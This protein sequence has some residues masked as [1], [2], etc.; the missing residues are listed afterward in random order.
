MR[1]PALSSYASRQT[2]LYRTH[3]LLQRL[4]PA[5]QKQ[6]KLKA[7]TSHQ[8]VAILFLLIAFP[9]SGFSQDSTAIPLRVETEV[10]WN[11]FVHSGVDNDMTIIRDSTQ[12]TDYAIPIGRFGHGPNLNLIISTDVANH[13][14]AGLSIQYYGTR[15]YYG[16]DGG[17]ISAQ[18]ATEVEYAFSRIAS[19]AVFE[20]TAPFRWQLPISVSVRVLLGASFVELRKDINFAFTPATPMFPLFLPPFALHIIGQYSA[21]NPEIGSHLSLAIGILSNVRLKCTV[22]WVFSPST[23]VQGSFS[24]M[25]IQE[26]QASEPFKEVL[27]RGVNLGYQ[28]TTLGA[29]FEFGF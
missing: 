11:R 4:H 22:G 29:G 12:Y 20:Y 28:G 5:K 26:I 25:V 23:T 14:S 3:C 13:I 19:Q 15:G 18:T 6:R 16:L 9:L 17:T 8:T 27:L 1:T 2:N 21:V 24:S 10:G 7:A